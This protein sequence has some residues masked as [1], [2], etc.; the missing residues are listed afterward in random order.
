MP[1]LAQ[2][3]GRRVVSSLLTREEFDALKHDIQAKRQKLT[4][5]CGYPGHA[6]T[7]RLG[8]PYFAHNPGGDGCG[9]GET[10]HH[11]LA[12]A[13]IVRAALRAGWDAEPERRGDGWVADVMATRDGV[14]VIFEVQ[15]SRQSL[16]E[17]ETRHR[18]YLE[19][20]VA[21]VAW[22][23]RHTDGL[24]TS[25]KTLPIFG[26]A[27]SQDD[28]LLVN[29]GPNSMPLSEAVER[30]L[31]RRLQHRAYVANGEPAVT[32]LDLLTQDCWNCHERFVVWRVIATKVTGICGIEVPS[33]YRVG[34]FSPDR[35][36]NDS[37]LKRAVARWAAERKV[38][39]ANMAR[40]YTTTSGTRYMAFVCPNCNRVSGD[41]PL[42]EEFRCGVQDTI[43]TLVPTTAVHHPH[44]CVSGEAGLCKDPSPALLARLDRE[45]QLAERHARRTAPTTSA[46][47]SSGAM[48]GA[49]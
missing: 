35:P 4:L 45:A 48:C 39:S 10:A 32:E 49:F 6:R 30:L 25:D 12:K 2:I 24:P 43:S 23:A 31:T 27:L 36:E 16:A 19:A 46:S 33:A 20:G 21:A 41:I 38:S 22:F 26:L 28:T 15:W 7:S 29:I 42:Q 11:I 14:Q 47:T 8:T 5:M 13:T 3:N 40:R 9:A 37:N 44:W 34:V 18:R 17:Y 1:L